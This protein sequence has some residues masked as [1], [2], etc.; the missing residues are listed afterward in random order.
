LAAD[1]KDPAAVDAR[2]TV[3][4]KAGAGVRRQE[5]GAEEGDLGSAVEEAQ[6]DHLSVPAR[7]SL[8]PGRQE[9]R[10]NRN[11]LDVPSAV[12]WHGP[13]ASDRRSAGWNM[14]S[15]RVWVGAAR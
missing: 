9:Q 5:C 10:E 8:W 14:P 2:F 15:H 13:T 7:T 6:V 4:E 1:S 11:A 3:L 12:G